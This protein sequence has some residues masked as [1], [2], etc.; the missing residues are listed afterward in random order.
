LKAVL[1][2]VNKVP[3]KL[4]PDVSEELRGRLEWSRKNYNF[5]KKIAD[6]LRFGLENYPSP[7][8]R[9]KQM[10]EEEDHARKFLQTCRSIKADV[11]ERM[12]PYF[13]IKQNLFAAA[14]FFYVYTHAYPSFD[15][16]VQD[17]K[18][19]RVHP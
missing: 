6:G 4:E 10:K 8:F 13:L 18:I 5:H 15:Q 9:P 2:T 14:L 19:R 7:A 3:F 17:A 16:A 11:R 12:K 1:V